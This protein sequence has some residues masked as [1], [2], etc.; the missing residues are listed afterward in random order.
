MDGLNDFYLTLPSWS[1]MKTFPNN[2]PGDYFTKLPKQVLLH[3]EWKAGMTNTYIP[4]NWY[5]VN[6]EDN[7]IFV[8]SYETGENTYIDIAPG[9]YGTIELLIT[10]INRHISKYQASLTFDIVKQKIHITLNDLNIEIW[11]SEGISE[12]LGLN[13]HK[14]ITRLKYRDYPINIQGRFEHVIVYCDIV[15]DQM[16]GELKIPMIGYYCSKDTSYGD[17]LYSNVETQY[18]DVKNKNFEVIHVW[19]TDSR[20]RRIPFLQG[21]SI[22]QLHFIRK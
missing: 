11:F 21:K 10:E 3:G 18:I 6:I 5:N 7:T 12:I 17:S 16:V 14:V 8:K 15:Q 19:M 1:S 22:I 4:K 20:G 9:Y 2:K 13:E